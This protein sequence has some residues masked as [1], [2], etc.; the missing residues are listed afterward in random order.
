MV[1]FDEFCGED[2]GINPRG[3]YPGNYG[4]SATIKNVDGLEDN[5]VKLCDY[6]ITSTGFKTFLQIF[7]LEFDFA[8]IR[9]IMK[10]ELIVFSN[11]IL[12]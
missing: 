6:E 3:W 8:T 5:S 4:K 1:L 2:V 7:L 9:T 11:K 12:F 10:N